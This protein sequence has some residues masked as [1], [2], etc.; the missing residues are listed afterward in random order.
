[1]GRPHPEESVV[2]RVAAAAGADRAG[3]F[4]RRSRKRC[5]GC[6]GAPTPDEEARK[7][8]LDVLE[9]LDY[10]IR[11]MQMNGLVPK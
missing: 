8:A 10:P 2:P 7:L 1:V 4:V 11:E 3:C 5:C 6:A 9:T